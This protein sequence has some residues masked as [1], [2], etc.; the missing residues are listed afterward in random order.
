MEGRKHINVWLGTCSMCF[1]NRRIAEIRQA[2]QISQKEGL[3]CWHS[4]I[5]VSSNLART[6][7][8]EL[9]KLFGGDADAKV[10]DRV[11][12]TILIDGLQAAFPGDRLV[13]EEG[14]VPKQMSREHHWWLLD[15]ID[16]SKYFALRCSGWSVMIAIIYEG[17]PIFGLVHEPLSQRLWFGIVGVGAWE[18]GICTPLQVTHTERANQF[19]LV[20]KPMNETNGWLSQLRTTLK[21]PAAKTTPVATSTPTHNPH[22]LAVERL[23]TYPIPPVNLAITANN[24]AIMK[25]SI[26]YTPGVQNFLFKG[27]AL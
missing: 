13:S 5:G 26:T 16:G 21:P 14:E 20:V 1:K 19:R 4:E 17:R 8:V 6:A 3:A 18:E 9:L 15:P 22:G 25:T 24:P 27:L 12:H 11:A 23:E 10:A 2:R 7:G